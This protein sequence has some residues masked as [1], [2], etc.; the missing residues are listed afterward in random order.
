M[1]FT[2][3][4]KELDLDRTKIYVH[5]MGGKDKNASG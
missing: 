5:Y 1:K 4:V 3:Y 2:E